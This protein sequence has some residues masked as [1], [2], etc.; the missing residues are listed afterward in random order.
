[1]VDKTIQ[2]GKNVYTKKQIID[3]F[4]LVNDLNLTDSVKMKVKDSCTVK[5]MELEQPDL[6]GGK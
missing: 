6:F 1:M 4:N 5:L 2:I 3:A